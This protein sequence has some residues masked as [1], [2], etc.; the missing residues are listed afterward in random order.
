IY[1]LTF[2]CFRTA[3]L[4]GIKQPWSLVLSQGDSATLACSQSHGHNSMYWYRQDRGK[5]LQL[6]Y[7]FYSKQLQAQ[8]T[9]PDRFKADQPQNERCN[10]NISSAEPGDSAVYFCA[11]S[12]DTALQSNPFFL[13]KCFI[14]VCG[15]CGRTVTWAQSHISPINI[16]VCEAGIVLQGE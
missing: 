3:R 16:S 14:D 5:G 2:V 9:V 10:L 6:L 4:A 11:S 12:I 15:A 13:Q 8:G 1:L 7:S